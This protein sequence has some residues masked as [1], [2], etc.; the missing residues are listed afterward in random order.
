MNTCLIEI[1]LI[2]ELDHVLDQ[3]DGSIWN[4][5]GITVAG[6]TTTPGS[7]PH[8][9]DY[10]SAL[11]LDRWDNLYVCDTHNHRVQRWKPNETN[12]TTVA[13]WKNATCGS[14]PL[15]AL[16]YP[17]DLAVDATGGLY[18]ADSVNHRIVHWSNGSST[19]R[20]VAGNG[21]RDLF[22]LSLSTE[23]IS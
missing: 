14:G 3:K 22:V 8:Q 10:P 20:L 12:G 23:L 2:R 1:P 7:L 17:I 6:V 18:I 21:K 11:A 13:G 4:G 15:S 16:C 19:G 9:L 5:T